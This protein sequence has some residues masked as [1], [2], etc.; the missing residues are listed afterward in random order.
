MALVDDTRIRDDLRARLPLPELAEADREEM[1]TRL[2][3]HVLSKVNLSILERMS[4]ESRHELL[5]CCDKGD[6]AAVIA[7]I[8]RTVGSLD[9]II[10]EATTAVVSQFK[11]KLY[12]AHA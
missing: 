1:M 5:D 11:V 8:E 2:V 7:Y 4:E 10:K 3:E 9:P 12:G 6:D